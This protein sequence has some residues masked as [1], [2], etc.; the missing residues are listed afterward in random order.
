MIM[1]KL[2]QNVNP[3]PSYLFDKKALSVLLYNKGG[4]KYDE[5]CF[6]NNFAL[7]QTY[8]L[9]FFTADALFCSYWLADKE[10]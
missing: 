3:N 5:K 2:L 4:I 9:L 1:R 10:Q 6:R 7:L 8:F